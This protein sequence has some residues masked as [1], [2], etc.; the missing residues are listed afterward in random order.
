MI[1]FIYLFLLLKFFNIFSIFSCTADYFFSD[2]NDVNMIMPS[3]VFRITKEI[4]FQIRVDLIN[5]G[6]IITTLQLNLLKHDIDI[7]SVVESGSDWFNTIL[8]N[9]SKIQIAETCRAILFGVCIMLFTFLPFWVI[10]KQYADKGKSKVANY[11]IL[12]I[13]FLLYLK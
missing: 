13:I 4:I 11:R 7:P 5:L 6:I 1:Y 10:G 12:N 9:K 3:F 8:V 2:S